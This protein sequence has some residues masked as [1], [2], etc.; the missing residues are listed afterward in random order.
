MSLHVASLRVCSF[1][2]QQSSTAQR[3]QRCRLLKSA[4]QASWCTSAESSVT[5]AGLPKAA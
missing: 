3:W 4:L 5:C 1:L 2:T